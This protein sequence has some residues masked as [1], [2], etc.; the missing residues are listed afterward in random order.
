M[1]ESNSFSEGSPKNSALNPEISDSAK[2]VP[3][4]QNDFAPPSDPKVT[5]SAEPPLPPETHKDPTTQTTLE[6]SISFASL[7]TAQRLSYEEMRDTRRCA[8]HSS[9]LVLISICLMNLM[10]LGLTWLCRSNPALHSNSSS[11]FYLKPI[12]YYSIS[13]FSYCV[14]IGFP[15]LL[16]QLHTHQPLEKVVRF[17]SPKSHG[18]SRSAI[19]CMFFAGMGLTLLANYPTSFVTQILQ[20]FGISHVSPDD[21]PLTSDIATQIFYML[22]GTLIPPLVEELLFRGVILNILRQHGD[23]FAIIMSAFIFGLYHGNIP[24]FV[25]AFLMG[26]IAGYLYIRTGSILIPILIHMFNNGFSCL[27]VLIQQWYGNTVFE[28]F[29]SAYFSAFLLLGAVGLGFLIKNRKKYLPL[30][31]SK[32]LHAPLSVRMTCGIGNLGTIFLILNFIMLCAVT[33]IL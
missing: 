3:T 32:I 19:I 10:I 4:A 11:F 20:M 21:M 13:C 12:I 7:V 33:N 17:D 30:P 28:N 5:D 6:D 26:L 27:S 8:S 15:A 16:Y 2:E 25:F 14:A 24:Q 29:Q 23:S 18:L 31:K 1:N 9:F 22:Y